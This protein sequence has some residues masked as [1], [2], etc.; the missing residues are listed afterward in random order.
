MIL[1]A[2][3]FTSS[4]HEDWAELVMN[5]EKVATDA[6]EQP[7]SEAVLQMVANSPNAIGYDGIGYVEGNNHVKMLS[8]DGKM[9]SASSI[10]DKSYKIVRPLVMFSADHTTTA[11]VEFLDFM[12][13]TE[14]QAL[15]KK[16]KFVPIP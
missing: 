16:A 11:V 2:R 9:A 13:S 1:V 15:V 5:N 4:T 12:T 3:D 7:T 10:L 14:G 8:V 6:S